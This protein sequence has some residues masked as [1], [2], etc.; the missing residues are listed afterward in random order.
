MRKRFFD[1]I[2]RGDSTFILLR[3]ERAGVRRCNHRGKSRNP[4]LTLGRSEPPLVGWEEDQV[5]PKAMD[6][7]RRAF[8]EK[9][10]KD[11]ADARE[12]LI[13][14]LAEHGD[15]RGLSEAF[16]RLTEA[17]DDSTLPGDAA[18]RDKETRDRQATANSVARI[19]IASAFSTGNRGRF[20]PSARAFHQS[21]RTAR[22]EKSPRFRPGRTEGVN[23]AA[24]GI[25]K[26]GGAT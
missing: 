2:R 8:D 20:S 19:T 9:R 17:L 5:K 21:C 25:A 10:C 12:E 6:A 14:I 1:G 11:K 4:T 23:I 26:V 22:R 15:Y 3:P 18:S 16:E 13:T 7:L 24:V